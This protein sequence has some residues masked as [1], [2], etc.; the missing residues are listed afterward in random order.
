MLEAPTGWL[1]GIKGNFPLHEAVTKVMPLG[2]EI[3]AAESS[4]ASAW[5]KT[6]NITVKLPDGSPKRYF[7]KVASGRGAH[8][9]VEGEYYSASAIEAVLRDFVPS[10]VGYG[11]Y[12]NGESQVYFFLGDF[13]DFDLRTPPELGIIA[14]KIA[15]LHLNSKSP[16]ENSG[17][18]SQRSAVCL[19]IP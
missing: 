9:L 19:R 13:H 11:E 7:L 17:F 10:P 2:T 3:I 18:Q 5:T 14:N 6:A 16:L 8:S 12:R 1:T 15:E 4:G